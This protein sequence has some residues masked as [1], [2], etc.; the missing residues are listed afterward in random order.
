VV[1]CQTGGD[2][3]AGAT[4]VAAAT[5]TG[6]TST[7]PAA[8][9]PK[10]G[11]GKGKGKGKN[12][13]AKKPKTQATESSGTSSTESSGTSS[14]S[15]E[16]AASSQEG[17][18]VTTN[19]VT[20]Q[21][22]N[23][24]AAGIGFLWCAA[25]SKC[26]QAWVEPCPQFGTIAQSPIKVTPVNQPANTVF[27]PQVPVGGA[28]APAPAPVPIYAPIAVVTGIGRVPGTPLIY[29]GGAGPIVLGGQ[30]DAFGCAATS[31]YSWC[32]TLG[33]CLRPFETACPAAAIAV[34]APP[35]VIG[36]IGGQRDAHGCVTGGGY[37]WCQS[38]ASCVRIWETPCQA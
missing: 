24:A 35:A 6:D 25:K 33:Q 14:S 3:T 10:K 5:G 20:D 30:A 32:A 29:P 8:P 31:G 37:T 27:Q 36:P 26:L 4:T 38:L 7:A 21:A 34:V 9:A 16:A 15:G 19:V 12:K 28:P 2:S 11:K 13:K 22:T 17:P 23:C 18:T 1:M